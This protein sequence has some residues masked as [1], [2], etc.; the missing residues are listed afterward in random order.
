MVVIVHRAVILQESR[1]IDDQK[2]AL[3]TCSSDVADLLH[4]AAGE[5]GQT[6]HVYH[7]EDRGGVWV[8]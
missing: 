7:C 1:G 6:A 8:L 3:E 4:D 5:F 2:E